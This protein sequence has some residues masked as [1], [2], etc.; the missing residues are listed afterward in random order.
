MKNYFCIVLF[1]LSFTLNSGAQDSPN[2]TLEEPQ[3][4]ISNEFPFH[5]SYIMGMTG[6]GTI[7]GNNLT[8]KTYSLLDTPFEALLSKVILIGKLNVDSVFSPI[9]RKFE[10][11]KYYEAYYN[12]KQFYVDVKDVDL[13]AENASYLD[14]LR[15]TS[16][17]IQDRFNKE[18]KKLAL[19]ID[20]IQI[21]RILD[22]FKK[23]KPH[24]LSIIRSSVYDESEYT[25]G[26][27]FSVDFL[28]PTKKTIKY[29]TVNF[30]GYNAV[31]DK[32]ISKGKYVQ[33]VKC[34]GP[35]GAEEPA[36]YSFKYVWFTDL[37]EYSKIT[38]ITV[39]YMDGTTKVISNPKLIQWE[40][41]DREYYF[42][43]Y[44][45]LMNIQEDK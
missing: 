36:S 29:I 19:S 11:R 7:V 31:D 35:I 41:R 8:D 27:G 9:S 39:Q 42:E 24:G 23:H 40:S 26:T 1:L 22:Y 43:S 3:K 44:P 18:T 6:K 25:E 17:E 13:N 45:D 33:S 34:V 21:N 14:S 16:P 20:L 30:V 5:F 28:N 2:K 10:K 12:G 38:S 37:V 4:E 15:C 32:V